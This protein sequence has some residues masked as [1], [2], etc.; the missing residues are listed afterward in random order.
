MP[1]INF[2]H[3]H[4]LH[5]PRINI[6]ASRNMRIL[7]GIQMLRELANKFTLFFLPVFLFQLGQSTHFLSSWGLTNFQSGIVLM[8]FFLAGARLSALFLTFPSGNFIRKYGF[9]AGLILSHLLYAVMLVMFR[10]SVIDTRWLALGV[11]ADGVSATLM[12]GCFH[13]IFSKYAHQTRMGKD[14]GFIR[15]L[16]NL[17]WMIAPALSG[18]IIFLLGYEIL[19]TIGLVLVGLVIILAVFLD[20]PLERDAVSFKELGFWLSERKFIK[21]SISIAG[22]T[23]YDVAIFIWPLY[24]FLLL[25]NTERVGILYSLSFLLSMILSLFIGAKL[26]KR[27]HK[28]PF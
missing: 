5:W 27:E 23:L 3:S 11:F 22:K 18:I 28:R 8:S 7:F 24:V 10:M 19:F 9:T 13:T 26:D 12:W 14:L 6:D 2:R 20:I 25:G 1:T 16:L 17:I 4:H 15:I 21:L